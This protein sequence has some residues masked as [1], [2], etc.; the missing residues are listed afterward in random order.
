M[1]DHDVPFT[2][3]GTGSD[4]VVYC[5]L[6]RNAQKCGATRVFELPQDDFAGPRVLIHPDGRILIVSLRCCGD[7]PNPG[8]SLDVLWLIES[9]DGGT[10]WSV[11]RAIG[12]VEPSGDAVLGPGEFSVSVISSIV[13]GGTFYQAAPLDGYT[14]QRANVGDA[15]EGVNNPFAFGTVA[16]QDPLTPI[17]A[18]SD[19]DNVYFRKWGG[20]GNYND[21]ATWG[22]LVNLG[23]GSEP[24]LVGGKRGVYL[25]YLTEDF[26]R[27]YRVRRWGGM[28]FG[29]SQQLTPKASP[30]WSD[31]FQDEGGRLHFVWA[32]NEDDTIKRRFSRD[33]TSWSNVET[34]T[35]SV[36]STYYN[37]ETATARDGGGW[38]VW[39]HNGQG[40]VEAVQFGPTGPVTDEG[41]EADDC[42]LE[43]KVGSARVVARE[44][45]LKKV[46]GANKYRTNGDVRVNGI[47]LYTTG[48]GAGSAKSAATA[49][50]TIDKGARTLTTEGKVETK[51]GNIVLD[52][53]KLEW[54]IPQ[55]GGQILDL[56]GNPAVFETGD[57]KV[58]FL[59]LPVSGQTS[60]K[61]KS[62]GSVEIPVH[63]GLPEPFGGVGGLGEIT[64]DI[65]LRANVG[66]G[67]RLSSLRIHAKNVGLGI[68]TIEELIIDYI[69][70]P[71]RLYGKANL[72]LPV[73]QSALETEF[74]LQG[75]EFDYARA[76][77]TFPSQGIP[78]ATAVYLKTIN[79]GVFTDPTKI[80]GGATINGFGQIGG[81]A[82]LSVD[83]QVSYTFPDAPNPGVFRVEGNGKLVGVDFFNVF[84]QY[85][86]SGKITFGGRVQLGDDS[87]GIF[88]AADGA[89]DTSTLRFDLEGEAGVCALTFCGSAKLLISSKAIAGCLGGSAV[90]V[91]AAYVWNDGLE[92]F[93]SCDLDD[94]KAIPSSHVAQNGV[95]TVKVKGG[96]PLA[97]LMVAGQGGP[98]RVTVTGP[99]G[100]TIASNPDQSQGTMSDVG[101]VLVPPGSNT[102]VVNLNKPE[103]GDWQVAV[104]PGSPA[105]TNISTA[106]ALPEPN[107]KVEV[108]GKGY[109]R[110]L[111]WR[112]RKIDGQ[113]VRIVENGK[114]AYNEIV[115]PKTAR[116]SVRF[117]PANGKKGKRRLF[118]L[119]E[120]DGM[121]RDRVRAGTYTAPG[122]QRPSKP[123]FVMLTR[124]NGKLV[125]TWGR[126]RGAA[127]YAV[128][129]KLRDGRRIVI[130]TKKRKHTI[131]NVPGID[132]GKISV[133]GIAR[134]GITVG[135]PAKAGFKAKPKKLKKKRRR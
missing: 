9:S 62:D 122:T 57:F 50:I 5:R 20:S 107:V 19:L 96:Q 68:A 15:G 71:S 130:P 34:L 69:G 52:R 75:G 53:S 129:A 36:D 59:G 45:C 109:K 44:G 80:E 82:V 13:T 25:S 133:Y 128:R 102:T 100:Q 91:G 112:M 22:P 49:T 119:I 76:K 92:G 106:N 99:S 113:V 21:L 41:E 54:K 1:W 33:G 105:V 14:E 24:E 8:G 135:K 79:F 118:A 87:L 3:S 103:G 10:T 83:G 35:P 132:S 98:P 67:L 28:A 51:V 61:I 97:S 134:D 101:V 95:R 47:D 94:Y 93:W 60:P 11:P 72:L 116:G 70:D 63:L 55:D 114:G 17:A 12:N 4:L 48:A 27:Q 110:E 38:A 111:T 88:G 23:P 108:T 78:V 2:G 120:Q 124:R 42:P 85:E 104:Q 39:D 115:T 58:E 77:L 125:V 30:L 73:I 131:A 127:E 26:P 123:R 66:Q 37:V 81:T 43:L 32:E 7:N 64:G 40:P 65:V 90:G 126:S 29:E 84:G 121:P 89:L 16:F 18:M 56:A 86:T 31:F 6:P 46:E 74:Q 117:R